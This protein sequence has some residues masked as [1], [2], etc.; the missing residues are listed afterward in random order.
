MTEQAISPSVTT[1]AISPAD[2]ATRAPP[3]STQ[4]AITHATLAKAAAVALSGGPDAVQKYMAGA[5]YPRD[6][7]WCGEFAAS[8]VSSQ[9]LKPPANP[10]VASNWR[11]WGTVDNQPQEGDVAVRRGVPTGQTGSHVTFVGHVNDDGTFTGVGGNQG[12]TKQY[13][14]DQFEF[15]RPPDP[16]SPEGEQ[17]VPRPGGQAPG[18]SPSTAPGRASEG[19]LAHIRT[20]GGTGGCRCPLRR[21]AT[22]PCPL[23]EP[24]SGGNAVQCRAFGPSA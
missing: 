19:D 9:G 18:T 13:R 15:R 5:G 4:S 21:P 23:S 8:V 1:H 12:G 11:N 20:A 22:S 10:E 7:N 3:N 24:W 6:G 14:A 2:H 17:G 16:N